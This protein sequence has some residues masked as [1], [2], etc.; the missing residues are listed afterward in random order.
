MFFNSQLSNFPP[1]GLK[2]TA[3]R[4]GT[5]FIAAA[6]ARGGASLRR[7]D[8]AQVCNDVGF[9]AVHVFGEKKVWDNSMAIAARQIVSKR[10]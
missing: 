7:A 2:T 10:W 9:V 3:T 5:A 4:T 6:A 8:A 1:G